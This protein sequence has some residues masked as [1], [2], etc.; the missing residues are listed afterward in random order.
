LLAIPTARLLIVRDTLT[1]EAKKRLSTHFERQGVDPLR[2]DL[3]RELPA[4]G[5]LTLFHG[6][7]ITLDTHPWSG[8]T[9]ACESLWMGVPVITLCG[10]RHAGRMASTILRSVGLPEWVARTEEDYCA[11]AVKA[12]VDIEKLRALRKNLRNKMAGS[13]VCDGAA[14]T[15]KLE[16]VFRKAWQQRC[17]A[18]QNG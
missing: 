17:S 2:I 11:I 8:H 3:L 5:Y 9:A 4:Q 7:D 18:Q 13:I 14:F 16:A 10:N 12:A 15:R 6:I 1:N